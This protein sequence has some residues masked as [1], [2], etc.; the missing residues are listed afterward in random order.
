MLQV[1]RMLQMYF[2]TASYFEQVDQLTTLFHNRSLHGV[3][4]NKQ[5]KYEQALGA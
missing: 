3:Q 4:Q 2:F 5:I 1:L